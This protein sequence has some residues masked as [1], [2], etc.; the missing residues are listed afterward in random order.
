MLEG[1]YCSIS[2][3]LVFKQNHDNGEST[4]Y[5]YSTKTVAQ[6]HSSRCTVLS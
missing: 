1:H 6:V 5:F 2:T 4:A 3:I